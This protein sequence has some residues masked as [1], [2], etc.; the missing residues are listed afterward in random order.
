M[1]NDREATLGLSGGSKV[2]EEVR[3]VRNVSVHLNFGALRSRFES[4]CA[5]LSV[6]WPPQMLWAG[7][8]SHLHLF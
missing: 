5:I 2:V 6:V 8:A 1:A 3:T 7:L 4:R